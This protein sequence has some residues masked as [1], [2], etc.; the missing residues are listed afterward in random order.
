[1]IR[2][3]SDAATEERT[4]RDRSSFNFEPAPHIS[5]GDFNRLHPAPFRLQSR[6]GELGI[7]DAPEF[8]KFVRLCFLHKRKT[9]R[10]NLA[11]LA[12][13]S[14]WPESSLRAEQLSVEQ[15]AGMYLRL[16]DAAWAE[17]E[18]RAARDLNADEADYLPVLID[19]LLL[20][21]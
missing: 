15:F 14:H 16:G 11:A 7:A 4:H 13:V 9:I 20:Q 5:G 8:L 6:A 1:M 3:D 19:A 17:R 2:R 12:D 18:A 21:K 10:N